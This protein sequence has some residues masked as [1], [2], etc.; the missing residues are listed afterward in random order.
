MCKTFHCLPSE[1]DEEDP[2]LMEELAQIDVVV[3]SKIQSEI[4]KHA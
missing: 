2:A 1:L 4:R 3:E